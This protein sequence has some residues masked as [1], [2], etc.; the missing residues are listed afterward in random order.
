MNSGNRSRTAAITQ[1]VGEFQLV[2]PLSCSVVQFFLPSHQQTRSSRLHPP[3]P[4]L[5][6]H[7]PAAGSSR[8]PTFS[9]KFLVVRLCRQVS[10]M[11]CNFSDPPTST[12]D[13]FINFF[14]Y[15][16][17]SYSHNPLLHDT[18]R[19]KNKFPSTLLGSWVRPLVIKRQINRRKS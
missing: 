1:S 13:P 8:L 14:Q 10:R 15:C 3:S 17:R 7:T 5:C 16:G 11:D 6:Q 2:L 18:I 9:S 19:K 4:L 12:L